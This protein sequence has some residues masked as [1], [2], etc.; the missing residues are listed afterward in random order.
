MLALRRKG[1]LESVGERNVHVGDKESDRPYLN[2]QLQIAPRGV[3]TL[4]QRTGRDFRGILDV[5][6]KCDVSVDDGV[7]SF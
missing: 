1:S 7:E 2:L 3:I 4:S 6:W 5:A